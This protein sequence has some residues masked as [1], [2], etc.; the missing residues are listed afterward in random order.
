MAKQATAKKHIFAL[1]E[2]SF[3]KSNSKRTKNPG[4]QAPARSQNESVARIEQ[5]SDPRRTTTI[6]PR[7]LGEERGRLPF[8]GAVPFPAARDRRRRVPSHPP[9]RTSFP[10]PAAVVGRRGR[11]TRDSIASRASRARRGRVRD[12]RRRVNKRAPL[13]RLARSRGL[14]SKEVE[15]HEPGLCRRSVVVQNVREGAL[16]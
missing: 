3:T 15:T 10:P 16:D 14:C 9:F 12:R 5:S 1:I 11:S 7:T 2:M 6:L 4:E 13:C 8:V